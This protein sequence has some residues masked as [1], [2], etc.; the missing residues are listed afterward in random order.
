[1]NWWGEFLIEKVMQR[2]QVGEEEEDVNGCPTPGL[3]VWKEERRYV[4]KQEGEVQ[5][6]G[7]RSQHLGS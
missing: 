6:W 5:S 2:P 1:M 7:R 4:G 3:R